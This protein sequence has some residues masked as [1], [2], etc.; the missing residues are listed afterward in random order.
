M[1]FRG[2]G[3]GCWGRC[4]LKGTQTTQTATTNRL[5]NCLRNIVKLA[6]SVIGRNGKMNRS[7][8]AGMAREAS[9]F[10]TAPLKEQGCVT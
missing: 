5:Q 7:A 6:K 4:F 2:G 1:S 9:F 10:I 3:E 8:V